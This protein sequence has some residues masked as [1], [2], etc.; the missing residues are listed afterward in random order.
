[1][2]A[3]SLNDVIF[4]TIRLRGNSLATISV[5][6]VTTFAEILKR[7]MAALKGKI[8]GMATVEL[9]NASQG[10]SARRNVMLNHVA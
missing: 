10:W 4:A 2:A 8:R 6:G 9:R 1:M 7:L 5:S 3:I